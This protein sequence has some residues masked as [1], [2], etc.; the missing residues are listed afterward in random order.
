MF[1]SDTIN[2]GVVVNEVISVVSFSQSEHA[3]DGNERHVVR[4]KGWVT[5]RSVRFTIDERYSSR[6]KR[7][8]IT[9]HGIQW[10]YDRFEVGL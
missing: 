5:T 6:L 1:G 3:N 10:V 4:D 9:A 2:A 8:C 7:E